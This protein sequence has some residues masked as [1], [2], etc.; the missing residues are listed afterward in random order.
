M[1]DEVELKCHLSG[2]NSMGKHLM[3]RN[4]SGIAN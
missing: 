2:Q 4:Q 1:V 3:D